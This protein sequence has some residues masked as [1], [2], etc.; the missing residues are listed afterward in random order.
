[1]ERAWLSQARN[2]YPSGVGYRLL[3]DLTML[4]H[5]TFLAFVVFGG[6]LAW[7]WPR[8][9]WSHLLTAAWG[10][11]TILFS[12]RCPLTDVE[13]WARTRAGEAKLTGTGF[14]DHYIEGVLYPQ[15]YTRL[16]QAAA[17]VVVL[18]SWLGLVMRRRSQQLPAGLAP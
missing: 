17:A 5:F 6:F 9:I 15:E 3:A 7:N 13:D 11:A 1:M 14:I 12:I 4:V 18:G 10:F 8:V 2:A 16:I